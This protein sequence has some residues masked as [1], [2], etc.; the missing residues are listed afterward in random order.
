[1]PENNSQQRQHGNQ[2]AQDNVRERLTALYAHRGKLEISGT[3]HSYQVSLQFPDEH[4]NQV[5]NHED[6]DR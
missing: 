6:F 1:M 4:P 2:L 3:D 5:E